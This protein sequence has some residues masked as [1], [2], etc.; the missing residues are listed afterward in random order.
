MGPFPKDLSSISS[1]HHLS[2]N[3]YLDDLV[4]FFPLQLSNVIMST[5][6]FDR[7][8]WATITTFFKSPEDVW[9]LLSRDAVANSSLGKAASLH[10]LLRFVACF[11]GGASMAVLLQP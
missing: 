5:F 9:G 4:I 8:C 2:F 10:G 7:P 1:V 11:N 6:L 3:V